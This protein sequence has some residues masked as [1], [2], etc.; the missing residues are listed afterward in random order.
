M[1]DVT[2]K[3]QELQES[4]QKLQLLKQLGAE[5]LIIEQEKEIIEIQ[6]DILKLDENT[7]VDIF[8]AVLPKKCKFCTEKRTDD[9]RLE[10]Y[11]KNFDKCKR[12]APKVANL[13]NFGAMKLLFGYLALLGVLFVF[14]LLTNIFSSYFP[15]QRLIVFLCAG[16]GLLLVVLLFRKPF[17][18]LYVS[19]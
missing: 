19:M 15:D 14:L 10:C 7:S 6:Q 17:K 12:K 1:V 8:E 4:M 2:D 13:L 16:A 18:K 9:E 5:K 3:L 11:E